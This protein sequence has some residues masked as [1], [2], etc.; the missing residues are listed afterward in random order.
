MESFAVFSTPAN[1]AAA[2]GIINF[3]AFAAFGIDKARAERRQRR[4]SEATLLQLAFFGG[5]PGAYAARTLFRYKTRKQPF[6]NQ[7]RTIALIQLGA[8]IVLAILFI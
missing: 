1:I 6:C 3:A 8:L 4:I 7:L 5:T 2:L